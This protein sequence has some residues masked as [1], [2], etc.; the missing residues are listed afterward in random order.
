MSPGYSHD[1]CTGTDFVTI[2][3]EP[4]GD[5]ATG[6]P[7]RYHDINTDYAYALDVDASGDVYVTGH[8]GG[9]GA[10]TDFID[11]QVHGQRRTGMGCGVFPAVG[12]KQG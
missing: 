3:Y 1:L 2:K 6:W 10:N 7:Q 8:S 12:C 9:F 4:G 5:V 11:R